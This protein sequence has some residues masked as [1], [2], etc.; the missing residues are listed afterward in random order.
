M[1]RVQT[2][3]RC[4]RPARRTRTRWRFGSKR[5]FVATIEKLRWLPKPGFFPHVA[6]TFDIARQGSRM[7]P[8][9]ARCANLGADLGE[10]VGH[11][12]CRP[13]RLAAFA[14][15]RLR[16]LHGVD[17][18]DAEGDRHARLEPRELETRRSL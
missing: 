6:Q 14:E 1:Q 10:D 2:Y 13:R 7:P 11:L 9:L 8:A 15:P 16:L 18:E 3:A 4:T 5:R 17:G 12:E